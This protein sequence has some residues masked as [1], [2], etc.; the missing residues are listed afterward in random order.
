M[1]KLVA[2]KTCGKEI[3]KSAA[4]CPHCGARQGMGGFRRFINWVAGIFFLLVLISVFL[5]RGQVGATLPSCDSSTAQSEVASAMESA[6]MGRVLGLK[7]IKITEAK[8]LSAND[9][10]RRCRGT[11]HLSN[12]NKYR[13][14]YKFYVDAQ[15]DVMVEAQVEGL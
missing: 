5:T 4:T 13:I 11:A 12:A 7:L 15:N 6:P 2:C 8:E 1:R 10:E 3:A 14:S 9:K